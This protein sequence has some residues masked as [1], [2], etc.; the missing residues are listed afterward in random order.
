MTS[1]DDVRY[2]W[3]GQQLE[4][5]LALRAAGSFRPA[6]TPRLTTETANPRSTASEAEAALIV[7]VPPMKSAVGV[8]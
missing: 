3:S 2:C 7:P 4:L 6:L 5:G 1:D 8:R